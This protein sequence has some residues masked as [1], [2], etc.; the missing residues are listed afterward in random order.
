MILVGENT[1][2]LDESLLFLSNFYESELDEVTKN[3]S[4]ILEPS[5]L[6]LMGLVVAFVALAIITPIYS[7]TQSLGR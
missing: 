5:L 2:K 3:M 1:G 7:M 4:S 6:L